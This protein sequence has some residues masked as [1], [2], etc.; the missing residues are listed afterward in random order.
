MD[1]FTVEPGVLNE[2]RYFDVFWE[3][4]DLSIE[5]KEAY[6]KFIENGRKKVKE[7]LVA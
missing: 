4:S 6:L 2:S 1:F 5:E 7:Y 3:E